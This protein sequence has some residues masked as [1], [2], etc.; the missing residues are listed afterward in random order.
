MAVAQVVEQSTHDTKFKGSS[1][2][3]A[4]LGRKEKKDIF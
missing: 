1:E 3:L 2:A 4:G